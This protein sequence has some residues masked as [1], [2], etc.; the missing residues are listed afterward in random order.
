MNPSLIPQGGRHIPVMV[1][2]VLSAL[3]TDPTGLYVDG[4]LGAGGHA[5]ALLA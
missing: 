2:E 4:T 5:I 3:V 1:A